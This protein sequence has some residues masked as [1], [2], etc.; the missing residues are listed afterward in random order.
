MTPRSVFVAAPSRLHFGMFSFGQP[1]VRQFG[2]AGAMIKSP[3]LQLRVEPADRFETVGPLADRARE[4]ALRVTRMLSDEPAPRCRIEILSAPREHTGLG[5]GTQLSLSVAAALNAFFGNNRL[6]PRQLSALAGRAERSAIGTYGFDAGG[7][8]L[9]GGKLPDETISP[10][11]A[12]VSLPAAWRFVLIIARDEQGVS[13]LDERA[14]FRNLPPVPPE[15]TAALVALAAEELIPAADAADF[16]RFSAALYQFGHTAGHICSRIDE[17][18]HLV[19]PERH[20]RVGTQEFFGQPARV[21]G[22]S[23]WQ[24]HGDHRRVLAPDPGGPLPRFAPQP[25]FATDTNDGIDHDGM[26]LG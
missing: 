8:L 23:T 5:V 22:K 9:E 16:G 21:G 3:G 11:V 10:L 24:I 18:R 25:W 13:G 6:T 7:L 17:R 14:A 2:G 20:Y 15:T 1:R 19:R 12:Q 4:V 26:S